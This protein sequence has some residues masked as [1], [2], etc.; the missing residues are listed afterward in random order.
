MAWGTPVNRVQA[1]VDIAMMQVHPVAVM[2]VGVAMA[3]VSRRRVCLTV[4]L[5]LLLIWGAEVAIVMGKAIAVVL[6]VA[7]CM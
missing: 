3:M 7:R 5:M 1:R 2:V 4:L 6:V